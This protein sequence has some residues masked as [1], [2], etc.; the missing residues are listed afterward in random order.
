MK[1]K[2]LSVIVLALVITHATN[3]QDDRS[4]KESWYTYWGL[5]YA[6]ITYP[7]DLQ[8]IMDQIEDLPG[9]SRMRI[10]VDFLG[11]YLPVNKHRTAVGFIINGAGDRVSKDNDWVQINQYI[12]GLSAMHFF[13]RNIGDGF[14]ARGDIGLAKAI[15]QDSE[16]NSSGSDTGFGFLLGG[17][18]SYP[19][20][21]DTRL[22]F[23]LNY[24]Y[25]KIE[26]DVVSKIGISVGGLF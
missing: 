2:L 11:F 23:N 17:G 19:V 4:K 25:R 13:N 14:F 7:H 1:T 22:A 16:G 3:A 15:V 26:G 21:P 6:M 20:T 8:N 9:V 24:S 18:Y 10:E 12:Y 5:G